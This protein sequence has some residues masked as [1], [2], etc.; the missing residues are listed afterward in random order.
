[1][2]GRIIKNREGRFIRLIRVAVRE[3]RLKEPFRARDVKQA[4]PGFAKSTFSNFLSKHR[5]G[6]P[7]GETELFE[8]VGKGLYRL[9]VED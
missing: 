4:V 9:I 7:G 2:E 8:Q 6:N 1:M 3:D 5:F